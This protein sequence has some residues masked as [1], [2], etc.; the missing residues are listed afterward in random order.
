VRLGAVCPDT[1]SPSHHVRMRSVGPGNVVR[2]AR[3]VNLSSKGMCLGGLCRS[4]N[5]DFH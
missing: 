5:R 4:R 3:W 2:G 1:R